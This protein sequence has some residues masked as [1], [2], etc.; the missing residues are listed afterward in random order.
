MT[1]LSIRIMTKPIQIELPLGTTFP[2]VNIW[3]IPGDE[4]VLIDAGYRLPESFELL[5]KGLAE[6]GYAISDIKKVLITHEHPDHVGL[7]PQILEE[8]KASVWCH[9]AL[10]PWLRDYRSQ[11]KKTFAFFDIHLK[12]A[13]LPKLIL[14][15]IAQGAIQRSL[16]IQVPDSRLRYFDTGDTLFIGD[17]NLEVLHTPGHCVTHYG[18]LDEAFQV[19][20]GGDLLLQK[21]PFP[22]VREDP[23]IAGK[24]YSGLP[25]FMKSLERLKALNVNKVYPGHGDEITEINQLINRQVHRIHQRKEECLDWIKNGQKTVF[26]ICQKMYESPNMMLQFAGAMMIFGY[27][28]LLIQEEKISVS[29]NDKKEMIFD[30]TDHSR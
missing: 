27:T 14:E 4:P 3:L 19:F 29:Y 15:L 24:R 25:D 17:F 8:S 21:A 1:A 7:L 12:A 16:N 13:G 6:N 20:F 9:K 18:F 2:S 26:E 11:E 22:T 5:K 28:D 30:I 10:A 23:N